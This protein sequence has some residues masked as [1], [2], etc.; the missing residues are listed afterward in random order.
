MY[1]DPGDPLKRR[2]ESP[3]RANVAHKCYMVIV[4][5]LSFL[6]APA[7]GQNETQ[8]SC[9]TF[10]QVSNRE[11]TV[12]QASL[13]PVS[14]GYDYIDP[15]HTSKVSFATPI[16]T[17]IRYNVYRSDAYNLWKFCRV[18][19]FSKVGKG[20]KECVSLPQN[21]HQPSKCQPSNECV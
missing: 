18:E 6:T 7:V 9:L 15:Q 2:S 21:V 4:I 19:K 17:I 3:S 12:A 11:D 16:A 1:G 10:Q 13:A 14:N 5:R 8:Q 20:S